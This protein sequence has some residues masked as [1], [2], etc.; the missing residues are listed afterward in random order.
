MSEFKFLFILLLSPL[1]LPLLPSSLSPSPS[2]PPPSDLMS[3]GLRLLVYSSAGLSLIDVMN[4]E[5][6][7]HSHIPGIN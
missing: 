3:E 2:P 4:N 5:I 7:S 1:S 6:I